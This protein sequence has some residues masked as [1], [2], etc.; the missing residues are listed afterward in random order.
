VFLRTNKYIYIYI[1]IFRVEKDTGIWG[2]NRWRK[3]YWSLY[4]THLF[5]QF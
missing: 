2:P 1:Y 3:Q 4:K 5:S